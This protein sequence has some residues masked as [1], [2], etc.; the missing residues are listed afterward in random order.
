MCNCANTPPFIADPEYWDASVVLDGVAR[1]PDY[2]STLQVEYLEPTQKDSTSVYKCAKCQQHWYVEWEPEEEP[3][4]L[5]ALKLTSQEEPRTQEV[6]AAKQ[7][8][9]VIAHGGY[10]SSKCVAIGC[11]NQC[12]NTRALCHIHFSFI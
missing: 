12:L 10:G 3:T 9:S 7:S 4:P 6:I 8:L 11:Q 1:S 5:F 2:F